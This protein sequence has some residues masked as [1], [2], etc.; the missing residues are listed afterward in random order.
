MIGFYM[1]GDN[2]VGLYGGKTLPP[3][4]LECTEDDRATYS[5]D[6]PTFEGT[7]TSYRWTFISGVLAA[8]TDGRVTGTWSY[9]GGQ[10]VLDGNG[11][12]NF[13]LVVGDP[14]PVLTLTL[15]AG[16]FNGDIIATLH[17]SGQELK[18]SFTSGVTTV[19]I[20]TSK[21]TK[22]SVAYTSEA[23]LLNKVF[24]RISETKLYPV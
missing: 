17:P 21:A 2:P 8:L 20:D 19:P 3:G 12:W 16:G 23:N 7:S 1:S 9:T 5:A 22:Y 11:D 24:V 18:F 13:D 15:S 14:E 4:V 10:G 6:G